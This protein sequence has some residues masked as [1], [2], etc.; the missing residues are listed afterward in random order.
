MINR[1][2]L[3]SEISDYDYEVLI[4]INSKRNVK[5]PEREFITYPHNIVNQIS[6]IP[7]FVSVQLISSSLSRFDRNYYEGE[8]SPIES[9]KQLE[10]QLNMYKDLNE[11]M[12]RKTMELEEQAFNEKWNDEINYNELEFLTNLIV[13]KM[14]EINE[15]RLMAI[16]IGSHAT[17]SDIFNF[18]N[19]AILEIEL[20]NN[21]RSFA[22]VQHLINNVDRS[23]LSI[24]QKIE[25]IDS[26][27]KA[28]S[29]HGIGEVF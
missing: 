22:F 29:I 28:A 23:E 14:S 8:H 12:I 26:I 17:S 24:A 21:T 19:E 15:K 27:K 13:N 10:Y 2:Q 20:D 9:E 18:Y 1:K 11:Y 25:H 4:K 16:A 3:Y 7:E 5:D 6:E